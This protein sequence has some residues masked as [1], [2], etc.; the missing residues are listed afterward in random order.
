[1]CESG[2]LS[3]QEAEYWSQLIEYCKTMQ[4]DYYEVVHCLE[5]FADQIHVNKF[6]QEKFQDVVLLVVNLFFGIHYSAIK[7]DPDEDAKK[8]LKKIYA[9]LKQAGEYV[10]QCVEQ[11][12]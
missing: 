12:S 4:E 1:M 7:N 11:G 8:A 5:F 6:I 2:K 3:H 9:F 10:P